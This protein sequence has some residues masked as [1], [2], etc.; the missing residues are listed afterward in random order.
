M[1]I[2]RL[3]T[4]GKMTDEQAKTAVRAL[5]AQLRE[6]LES[7][8]TILQKR[9]LAILSVGSLLSLGQLGT[10]IPMSESEFADRKAKYEAWIVESIEQSRWWSKGT[11][12]KD[13]VSQEGRLGALARIFDFANPADI[14]VVVE[15][16]ILTQELTSGR[17]DAIMKQKM[18]ELGLLPC[19]GAG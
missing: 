19:H 11:L 18:V 2:M 17:Y 15:K 4:S 9:E 8:A 1:D 3:H 5:Q 14:G 6:G 10:V 16:V 13:H 12:A 7:G